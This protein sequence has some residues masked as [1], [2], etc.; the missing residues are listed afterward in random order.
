MI[1]MH[2]FNFEETWQLISSQ[3]DTVT[4]TGRKSQI[5]S[6]HLIQFL[7][8]GIQSGIGVLKKMYPPQS[9][10]SYMTDLGRC[11][12]TEDLINEEYEKKQFKKKNQKV[13]FVELVFTNQVPEDY[14]Q[15]KS[16]Y[17]LKDIME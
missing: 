10:K 3:F 17:S 7:T 12:I 9:Y 15:P 11:G 4:K 2:K 13:E 6:R 8:V 16:K 14:K 1:K 5:R